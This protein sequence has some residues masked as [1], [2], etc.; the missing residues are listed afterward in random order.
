MDFSFLIMI[1]AMGAIMYFLIWRPQQKERK[2]REELLG[3][4]QKGDR[5]VT[6]G[7]IHGTISSVND[8]TLK[9][10]LGTKSSIIINTDAVKQR[11]TEE[12]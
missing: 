10:D 11:L 2:E 8:G 5:I 6:T 12:Q 7:G 3:S 1:A 9:I 4:L